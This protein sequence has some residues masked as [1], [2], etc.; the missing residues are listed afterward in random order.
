MG[1]SVRASA[2]LCCRCPHGH[3]LKLQRPTLRAITSKGHRISDVD[4][5]YLRICVGEDPN[6]A[7]C[8]RVSATFPERRL[9]FPGEEQ[10]SINR[11]E[12]LNDQDIGTHS[13]EVSAFLSV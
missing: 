5:R 3:N 13:G 6:A 4:G 12:L 9:I 1:L 8:R 2:G 7:I 10:H 11:L